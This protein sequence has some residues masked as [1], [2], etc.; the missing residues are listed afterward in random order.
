MS[1]DT[2]AV[3]I[4]WGS[5]QRV[6]LHSKLKVRE[7]RHMGQLSWVTR[8]VRQ[9]SVYSSNRELSPEG[10]YLVYWLHHHA[11]FAAHAHACW[12]RPV[13]PAPWRN[14]TC[15]SRGQDVA[16]RNVEALQKQRWPSQSDCL[17][18]LWSSAAGSNNTYSTDTALHPNIG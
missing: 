5:L 2:L 10:S 15:W 8:V 9:D 12:I 1:L 14:A 7:Q 16:L 4:P 6:Q 13:S 18:S 17:H 11:V 3:W